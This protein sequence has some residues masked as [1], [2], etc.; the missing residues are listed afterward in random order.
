[1]STVAD[2]VGTGANFS[3][4]AKLIRE[5]LGGA[6]EGTAGALRHGAEMARSKDELKEIKR[7]RKHETL[8]KNIQNQMR[9]KRMQREHTNEMAG[10][11]ADAMQDV[12]RGFVDALRGKYY[13]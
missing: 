5:V 1:M 8:A 11:N 2:Q 9:M 7:R 3:Q 12:A 13:Q 4:W 6:A 10:F